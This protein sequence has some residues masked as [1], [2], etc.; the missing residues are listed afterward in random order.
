MYSD[1]KS[2]LTIFGSFAEQLTKL[3]FRL[4][5][6]KDWNLQQNERILRMQASGNDYPYSVTVALDKIRRLRNKAAHEADFHPSLEEALTVDQRAFFVWCWFLET[7]TQDEIKPYQ[8]PLNQQAVVDNQQKKIEELTAEIE[9]LQHTQSVKVPESVR[10]ERRR[11]NKKFAAQNRLTEAQTREIIDQQLRDAGW[12][13]DTPTLNNWTKGTLPQKGHNMAIAEWKLPHRRER[14]DYV[15]FIGERAVGIVEAKRYGETVAT[16]ALGQAYDYYKYLKNSEKY[17]MENVAFLFGANGRPYLSQMKSQSG[18]WFRDMRNQNHPDGPLESWLTPDDIKMKEM[19]RPEEDADSALQKDDYYPDFA[20][21]YYQKLAIQK[22]EEAI[23]K[24]KNRILLA[25]ATGTGKTRTAIALMYRLI[26]HKRARRILYLVDRQS[27]AQQTADALKDNKVEGQSISSIYGVKEYGDKNPEAHTRIHI[28]TVQGLVQRLFH[29]E[30]ELPQLSPGTY[31]FIIVDEAHRGYLEDREMSDEEMEHYDPSEYISQYRRVIDYFD[32]VAIGMTAT[33]ALNTVNI[34]GTPVYSYTYR[35]AVLDGYLMDHN[36]P[37]VITTELSKEGI[38]FHKDEE[39]EVFH[40]SDASIKKYQLPDDM[41]FDVD[42]FNTKV[43]TESFNRVVCQALAERLDPLDR[44]LGKTL[45]FA[46]R[47]SHADMI[48]YL[49][50][51][52]FA[53]AD[54]PLPANAIMKITGHDRHKEQ[55]IREFKNEEFPNIVVTVDLLT[56]GI[57]VPSIMNLVFMRRVKSRILFEQMLGRATRL[58][59]GMDYFNIY[60]AVGQFASM[61]KVTDMNSVIHEKNVHRSMEDLFQLVTEA[62]KE[63]DFEEYRDQLIAKVQRKLHRLN[64]K[65]RKSLETATGI[66]DLFQ[67]TRLLEKSDQQAM[68]KE[69]QAIWLIDAFHR[70][71]RKVLISHQDDM[72]VDVRQSYGKTGEG[73]GDYLEEF[74]AFIKHNVNAIAGI[75]VIVNRPRD[76]TLKELQQ[77]DAILQ[78]Q[79]FRERD[80]QSAWRQ[81]NKEATAANII[82]FI[83]QAALGTPLE[84]EDALVERAMNKVYGLAEW[85][86]TQMKWL[87]RIKKQLLLN[88][89]LGPNAQVAF[90]SNDA[91]RSRGGYKGM[92]R[93]FKD[94]TDEIVDVIND[95]IFA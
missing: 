91:F 65:E 69:G 49:L 83:R 95:I 40:E 53:K 61:E 56:T 79:G 77:I 33:P 88:N 42:A 36:A 1:V 29:N 41:D 75:G 17:Q 47:D 73:P 23:G 93:I 64:E 25:M 5:G 24:H 63:G 19:A 58:F 92:Q 84:S 66:K 37:Y 72:L 9:Q 80:L 44:E 11:K 60:D 20:G 7:F 39:V 16:S 26:K 27:L 15:L 81:V 4:D 6:L 78:T 34:F 32:A 2:S 43:V 8:K 67:W 52:A 74:N 21:R 13:A 30:E 76:L 10:A 82:S 3:I 14:A 86:P 87:E 54:K 94:K 48:V 51:E 55:H 38:H 62:E 57:D 46:A 71:S 12:E 45:I 35:Q 50:Q 68:V 70:D 28:A 89:V 90:D 31:D 22:I 85:T 59:P 18:I